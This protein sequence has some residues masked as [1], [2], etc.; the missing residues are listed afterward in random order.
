VLHG[1]Q[2]RFLKS[3][4]DHPGVREVFAGFRMERVETGYSLPGAGQTK[5]V[6]ELLISNAS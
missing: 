5:R 1:I 6:G 3:L 2:G 4:N